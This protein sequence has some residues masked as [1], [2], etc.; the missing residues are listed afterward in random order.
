MCF[1]L[2]FGPSMAA[3][4]SR[5]TSMVNSPDPFHVKELKWTW[6]RCFWPSM[7]SISVGVSRGSFFCA[8]SEHGWPVA[9]S[10]AGMKNVNC[11]FAV[12]SV[13]VALK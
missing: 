3:G 7:L 12:P 13:A 8:S 4:L 1:S 11:P 6:N 5:I 2:L 9:S 10:P